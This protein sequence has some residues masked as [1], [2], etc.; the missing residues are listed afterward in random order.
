M[1]AL[2]WLIKLLQSRTTTYKKSLECGECQSE[3]LIFDAQNLL[4]CGNGIFEY[5]SEA[6]LLHLIENRGGE[7]ARF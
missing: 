2:Q 4:I 6:D 5:E 7:E 3:V 1:N